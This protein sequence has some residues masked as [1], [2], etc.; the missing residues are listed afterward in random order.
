[1]IASQHLAA[2][3]LLLTGLLTS[4]DAFLTGRTL[5]K[6]VST[7][8]P[9]GLT[10]PD[11]LKGLPASCSCSLAQLSALNH[12]LDTFTTLAPFHGGFTWLRHRATRSDTFTPF[13]GGFLSAVSLSSCKGPS[14]ASLR[15]V[16]Q[17]WATLRHPRRSPCKR[18]IF[19]SAF[20]KLKP[21]R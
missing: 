2:S 1:M 9:D 19:V 5:T 11:P 8:A 10:A 18:S 3:P 21:W 14:Q 4:S 12:H 20:S 6:P 17:P 16:T 15:K 7:L 13:H